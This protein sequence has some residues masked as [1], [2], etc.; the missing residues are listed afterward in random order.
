MDLMMP[1]PS[2]GIAGKGQVIGMV[3]STNGRK[4]CIDWR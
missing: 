3:G 4:R 2:R 1:W